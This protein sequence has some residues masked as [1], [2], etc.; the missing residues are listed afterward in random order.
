[1]PKLESLSDEELLLLVSNNQDGAFHML[2]E[3]Y[4]AA[5]LIYAIK[6]VGEDVGEDLVQDVFIRTWNNRYTIHYQN[7]FKAYLFT[8]LRRRII[9]YFAKETNVQGY[10]EDLKSYGNE[11]AFEEADASIR[12]QSF[13][14]SI[15]AVLHRYG[16]QYQAIL[17][18][19]LQGYSNPEIAALLGLSEKTV[20][21]QYSSTLKIIRSNFSSFLLFLFF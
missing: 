16:P 4:K 14:D 19:R 1:M 13:S 7:D 12:T 10:L 3:R 21:N 15:F 8:A 5:L 11:F 17:K 6:R 9:D 20:R 2:Y 18:L